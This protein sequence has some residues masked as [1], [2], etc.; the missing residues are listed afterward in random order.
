MVA[1]IDRAPAPDVMTLAPPAYLD[2]GEG[3]SA[4]VGEGT[5]FTVGVTPPH[6]KEAKTVV[7]AT[8]R[9]ETEADVARA[10]VTV[11]GSEDHEL[12]EIGRA[13]V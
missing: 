3:R 13:H 10:R 2:A 8:I 7:A 4:R 9:L 6:E 1:A 12:V 11:A 5:P